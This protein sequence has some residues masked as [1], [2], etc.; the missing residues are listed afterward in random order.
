[1]ALLIF[2]LVATFVVS[3]WFLVEIG[4]FAWLATLLAIPLAYA[5]GYALS[6]LLRGAGAL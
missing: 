3:A 5:V 4:L 2:V 1:M 6:R